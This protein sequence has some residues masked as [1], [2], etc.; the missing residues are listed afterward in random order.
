MQQIDRIKPIMYNEN[1]AVQ[2]SLKQDIWT[3]FVSQ[4]Y[5]MKKYGNL[6]IPAKVFIIG[7]NWR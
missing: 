2:V 3:W 6:E 4:Y 1:K 7:R 5:E